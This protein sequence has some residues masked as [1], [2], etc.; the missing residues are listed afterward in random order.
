MYFGCRAF[1]VIDGGSVGNV[2]GL[3]G[4][5]PATCT[6][7]VGRDSINRAWASPGS[8]QPGAK[9]MK[10]P[11]IRLRHESR[12]TEYRAPLVPA[13][14]FK[15]AQAGV[16]ITVEESVQRAFPIADYVAAGCA[17]ASPGSWVD[18]PLDEVVLG[19]KE[20]PAQP[21]ALRARHAFFGHAYKGQPGGNDLLR[22]FRAGGGQLLDLEFLTDDAGR[23]V[24]GFGY[25]AGYVGA[26]LAVM[27]A[28]GTLMTPL[29][30]TTRTE[31]DAALAQRPAG[32]SDP[33]VLI[34]GALGRGGH[35]ARAAL[36]IAGIRPTCWDVAE[37]VVVDRR[38]L[39]NHDILVNT[40]G[41]H[42]PKPALLRW[43]DLDYPKRRLRLIVDVTCDIG[44]AYNLLPLHERTTTWEEPVLSLISSEHSGLALEVIAV[45]NLP[46]LIPVESSTEFS[47]DLLPHLMTVAEGTIWQRGLRAFE[48]ACA[49]A[50]LPEESQH[51]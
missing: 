10:M 11:R 47:G 16:A 14:A 7:K 33:T 22:R 9:E 48:L 17:I 1:G 49:S 31:L 5:V 46:S 6:S 30:P 4:R 43:A 26:A 24:A 42:A 40:V 29:R 41:V 27:H 35:G 19:L 15:L 18:G 51:G 23:R 34:A 32:H 25:W 13:D 12:A 28:R 39:L 20:L 37:T 3:L 50:Q 8:G 36:E 2:K 44:S 38:G 45:D 21:E